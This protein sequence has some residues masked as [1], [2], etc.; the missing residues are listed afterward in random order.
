[1]KNNTNE[2]YDILIIGAGPGGMTAGIYAARAM[3]NIAMIEKGAPGGKVTKTSEIENYPGFDNIQGYELAMKMFEQT[4]KLKIPYIADR[5]TN[6][7]RQDNL[8]KL[9]LFSKKI[10]LAKAV[11]VAT[12]TVERK[13]VVPGELELEGHGVSYCAVCDGA[14]YKEKDVV[15]VGGGYAALEEALYLARFV[16]KVY[17][18][19]R[20]DE[21]R[22]DNNIVNKVKA[23]PKINFIVDT[24]VTEIKDVTEKRVTTVVIKNV[25]TGKID[26]LPVSAIFPYIGAI[27]IS[28]FA[29][30]L[31]VLNEEG[32]FIVNNKCLTALP[33]LYAAGDVTNTTL[34]QIATA[35][36]DG[37][38]AA[39]FALEYLNSC[40]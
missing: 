10:L 25:K 22:A 7:I 38:K 39:Q 20:R 32:Y 5:V 13:L 9:E 33:G 4:Q 34:R 11:I 6:I 14:L 24:I 36:S 18:I 12:G 17:L 8:F 40:H 19:H 29:K 3:A 23:H 27:P 21:F 1:M 28:D 30:N 35:I 37:A 16:N 26:N 15:V 31:G 2:I